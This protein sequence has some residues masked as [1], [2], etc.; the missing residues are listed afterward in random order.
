MRKLFHVCLAALACV[1]VGSCGGSDTAGSTAQ[2]LLKGFVVADA[3]L[4][5]ATI[6]VTDDR[7]AEVKPLNEAVSTRTGTF[8]FIADRLPTRLTVT[9]T[10][11][12]YLGKPFSGKMQAEVAS[13]AQSDVL[14]VN[15]VSTLVSAYVRTRQVAIAQA[16]DSV[17]NYLALPRTWQLER[18][19][20][21]APEKFSA[22]RFMTEAASN[23]GFDAYVNTIAAE[24]GATS[25][26]SFAETRVLLG[27][28]S[29]GSL[30]TWA[31]SN[32]AAG[33]VSAAGGKAFTALL[34]QFGVPSTDTELTEV[35][36]KL[37]GISSQLSTLQS[38]LQD[39]KSQIGC[40][41]ANYGYEGIAAAQSKELDDLRTLGTNMDYLAHMTPETADAYKQGYQIQT[42]VDAYRSLHTDI[43][44][45]AVGS[46][47]LDTQGAVRNM[48]KKFITCGH[49]LN[50]AKTQMLKKQ[51][52][53]WAN[54]QVLACQLVISYYNAGGRPP[55]TVPAS[56]VWQS[57]ALPDATTAVDDCKKYV[58][59][60]A[61]LA[62]NAALPDDTNESTKTV[63]D[64][65]TNTL[66]RVVGLTE[67]Y[68]YFGLI[69]AS[70]TT[71][72]VPGGWLMPGDH[73]LA[74]FLT[75]C[76]SSNQ[77]AAR[78]CLLTQGW[79]PTGGTA[80]YFGSGDIYFWSAGNTQPAPGWSNW[81]MDWDGRLS[82]VTHD[83]VFG[84]VMIIR[85]PGPGEVYFNK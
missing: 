2:Q 58:T 16:N 4:V 37:D 82:Q 84:M 9:A 28:D 30:L 85:S 47:T 55:G 83:K 75:G 41:V 74:L 34:T 53:Y 14:Y 36:S 23:G 5:G 63:V 42:G 20:R 51:Y 25:T 32:L 27:D 40:E 49:F 61:E 73:D 6:T 18:F 43:Q 76:A 24:V 56:G 12:T 57:A 1:L 35:Q 17:R 31:A 70:Y 66:Y 79:G 26:R 7:G 65:R 69:I 52:D 38:D 3:P 50:A 68:S 8:L 80:D 44:T 72:L 67:S 11:G 10:G 21:F 78:R 62:V 33:V 48:S 13:F 22:S 39:I 45:M 64:T 81:V 54:A 29:G 19:K 15:P 59:N 71:E 60:L 77:A 46:S